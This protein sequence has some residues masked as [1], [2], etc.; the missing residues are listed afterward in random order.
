VTV[1]ERTDTPVSELVAPKHGT[2]WQPF[3]K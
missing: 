2:E 1:V 3:L